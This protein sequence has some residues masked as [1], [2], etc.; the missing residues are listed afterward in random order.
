MPYTNQGPTQCFNF[1]HLIFNTSLKLN[2]PVKG[3]HVDDSIPGMM[4][5]L[6]AQ[7]QWGVKTTFHLCHAVTSKNQNNDINLGSPSSYISATSHPRTKLRIETFTSTTS[8]ARLQDSES[9][10]S[11]KADCHQQETP[12]DG[13]HPSPY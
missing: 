10:P 7:P 2:L 6:T 11:R 1:Q 3:L 8:P 12:Q 13:W 5:R 4:A 9:T